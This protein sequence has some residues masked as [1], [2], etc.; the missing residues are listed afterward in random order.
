MANNWTEAQISE[1]VASVL[2]KMNTSAPAT[3]LVLWFWMLLPK[4]QERI[5]RTSVMALWQ[6]HR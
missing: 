2:K 4:R 3:T 6:K 5:F 1:I